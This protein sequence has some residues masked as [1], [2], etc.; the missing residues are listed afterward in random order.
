MYYINDPVFDA[1]MKAAK[2]VRT[3]HPLS[4]RERLAEYP[5]LRTFGSGEEI[6]PSSGEWEELARAYDTLSGE[7]VLEVWQAYHGDRHSSRA[8]E[9][10]R[11]PRSLYEEAMAQAEAA[12]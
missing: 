6:A 4:M 5:V 8:P 12:R 1:L 9:F 2:P 11:A 10:F 7:I 3:W